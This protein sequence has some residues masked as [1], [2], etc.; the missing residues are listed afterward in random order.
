[1]AGVVSGVRAGVLPDSWPWD[2]ADDDDCSSWPM[3]SEVCPDTLS[4]GDNARTATKEHSGMLLFIFLRRPACG[5]YLL[6]VMFVLLKG[7]LLPKN[8]DSFSH[9]Q[10]IGNQRA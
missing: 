4:A 5:L 3:G 8:F 2:C 10:L 6:T 1:M 7:P 9:H